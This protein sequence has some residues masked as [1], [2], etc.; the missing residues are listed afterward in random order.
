M[1]K[2]ERLCIKV[3]KVYDW[4]THPA[5]KE[6]QFT[7][8]DIVFFTEEDPDKQTKENLVNDVCEYFLPADVEVSCQLLLPDPE[9][10]KGKKKKH[11]DPL[12]KEVGERRD[13][14]DEDLDTTL[15]IV[16]IQKQ[17]QF[18][19][20]LEAESNPSKKKPVIAPLFSEPI[21]FFKL[22]KFILCAPEGTDVLCHVYDFDCEGSF[23]CNGDGTEWTID[24]LLLICQSIQVEAEVK[25]EVEGKICQPRDIIPIPIITKECPEFEF[26][27]Q[28]PEIFPPHKKK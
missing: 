14:F 9:K 12:C 15:Q 21:D 23:I 22:E 27:P 18:Q 10:R 4:I 26:P 2:L 11:D 3:P 20:V 24:L 1:H 6:F 13:F 25:L 8:D 17:G 7:Q 28:C 5:E 19:I 16:K